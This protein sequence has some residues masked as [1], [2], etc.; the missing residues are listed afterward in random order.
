M[1]GRG[2]VI[3]IYLCRIL[4]GYVPP[5]L[6]VMSLMSNG[7]PI[8]SNG[9]SVLRGAAASHLEGPSGAIEAALHS[10]DQRASA[11]TTGHDLTVDAGGTDGPAP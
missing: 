5:N 8:L 6:G 1:G 7:Q 9:E 4:S 2:I 11:F 3:V 10:R